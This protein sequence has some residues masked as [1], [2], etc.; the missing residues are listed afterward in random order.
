MSILDEI[1]EVKKNELACLKQEYTISRFSDSK[2]FKQ[3]TRSLKE[4]IIRDPNI[5]IVA[6]IKKASPSRGLINEDFNHMEIAEKYFK[7]EVAAVSVLTDRNFFQGDISFLSDIAAI[8]PVP[9]L[10]KDFIID[11]Y[12]IFEAKARGADIILLI[13][14][15]LSKN[16]IQELSSAASEHGLETLLELHSESQFQK[17]NFE[18]NDIIGINNRNLEDFTTDLSTTMSISG[19][20]PEHVLLISES[21]IQTQNDIKQLKKTRTRAILVGEHLM[22]SSDINEAL[23]ELKGWCQDAD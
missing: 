2:F 1:I 7:N 22:S 19:I 17:I 9:L 14:E 20:I 5:S 3:K 12:Q 13:A 10:R 21:G 18:K 4:A 8:K 6:E 16:Q 15:A 11:E 23:Q